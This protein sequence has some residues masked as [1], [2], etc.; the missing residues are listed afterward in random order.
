MTYSARAAINLHARN[1][2][3]GLRAASEER[4]AK[5]MCKTHDPFDI[6]KAWEGRDNPDLRAQ[7]E[8][9]VTITKARMQ[10]HF[11]AEVI[12]DAEIEL[13]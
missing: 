11:D 13:G 8:M 5:M 6:L 3:H 9:Y 2:P 1:V 10:D 12:R 7:W 4:A